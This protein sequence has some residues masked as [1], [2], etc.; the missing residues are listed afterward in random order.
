MKRLCSEFER[1]PQCNSSVY[2]S[3]I[4]GDVKQAIRNHSQSDYGHLH[5]SIQSAFEEGDLLPKEKTH[6]DSLLR[7]LCM[8]DGEEHRKVVLGCAPDALTP[9]EHQLATIEHQ[10]RVNNESPTV[11]EYLQLTRDG[12]IRCTQST[13]EGCK[14]TCPAR[15]Q[16]PVSE[17][18]RELQEAL[19]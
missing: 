6:L 8:G 10:F 15:P 1:N 9:H 18:E 5:A 11:C 19:A 7:I 12:C 13:Q 4:L 3:L 14:K 2:Y 17:T 16:E